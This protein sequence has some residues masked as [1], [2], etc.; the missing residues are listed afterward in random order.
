MRHLEAFLFACL[1]VHRTGGGTGETSYYTPINNLLDAVG[2]SL[3][4]RVRCIMQLKNLGAGSPDGGLFTSEQFDRKTS[5]VKDLSA[6]AR[7]VIEVKSPAEALSLT[8]KNLQVDKYWNRYKLVLV[9][10]ALPVWPLAK[11]KTWWRP[12]RLASSKNGA[13][14]NSTSTICMCDF[15]GLQKSALSKTA[16]A[17]GWCVLSPTHRMYA[18]PHLW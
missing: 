10:T 16:T 15:L 12:T 9:T 7:G 5:H 14:K 6:P 11:S 8:A 13:S 2:A 3:Q 17:V 18:N 1:S 4:P